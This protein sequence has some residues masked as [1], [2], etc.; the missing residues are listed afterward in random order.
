[1]PHPPGM[2]TVG[3]MST[4]GG[5]SRPADRVPGAQSISRALAV[6]AALRDNP[7]GVGAAE[8]AR[9]VGLHT[10]TT[11]RVLRALLAEGYLAK[12]ERGDQYR[13]GREAFLLGRAA[14]RDLGFDLV[15]PVLNT[16]RDQT[17]ESLNLVIRE[18]DHGLVILRVES[19][20]SLRFSQP[21][22]SR[23]PLHST[24]TGKALL[25]WSP[26]PA[27]S[28]TAM[29]PLTSHTPTTLTAPDRLL[30]ELAEIKDRGYSINRGERIEGVR[31]V[32]APVL[33]PGAP[34]ALFG[35]VAIQGPEVRMPD[36][37]ID[38]LGQRVMAVAKELAEVLPYGFR[39]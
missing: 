4:E 29:G 31:G 20:Q 18:G 1:M 39:I 32:A 5:D 14:E 8:I 23:L 12:G 22:G 36:S 2:T 27:A 19:M 3:R 7:G 16:A 10:S 6:L 11:H 35:A 21:V 17:G 30:R 26:D 37:R 9:S 38:E 15:A 24:S 33:H 34:D 13:L 25:A 28:V